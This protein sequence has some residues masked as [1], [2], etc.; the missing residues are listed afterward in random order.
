[1]NAMQRRIQSGSCAPGKR[2]FTLIEL[3]VV[4]A[5]I[6]ILAAMLLPALAAAKEKAIKTQCLNN[7]H[8][9]AVALFNY[10]VDSRDKL[11]PVDNPVNWVWDLP[12]SAADEMIRAGMNPASFYCPGTKPKFGDRENWANQTPA[13]GPTSSMWGYGMDQPVAPVDRR[14]HAIG[15]ALAFSGTTSPLIQSNQN[16]TILAE[17]PPGMSGIIS[18]SE[19]VLMADAILSDGGALPGFSSPGN[20]YT[21]I[22]GG[23]N[24]NGVTYPHTSPHLKGK[25]PT[26]GMIG[27]KD[28]HV[29]WRK[30]KDMIPRTN[31]GKVFWW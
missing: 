9:I 13:I 26:G 7:E 31:S 23:L 8:Q 17:V 19:R 30:F 14:F 18:P 15:Y 21:A 29:S 10:A 6:A 3:L 25:V 5:I 2:A 4:I 11:P 28:G 20:N 22:P 16:R 12:P 24:Y 27:Y 1:M